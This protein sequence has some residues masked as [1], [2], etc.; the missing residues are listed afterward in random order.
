[1]V[2]FFRDGKTLFAVSTQTQLDN[3]T[4]E[5]LEWLF[6]GAKHVDS[7]KVEGI[8]VGP[9][10]E[11][12]TPWSTNAVEIT[13]NMGL[14]GIER[15]E[16]FTE[17]DSEHSSFD[18]MLQRLYKNGV[19]Q[20]VFVV[21][22]QPEPIVYI[23][24]IAEYNKQEGL[25]LNDNEIEYLQSVASRIGR[26]LTDSEVF[27]F[28]QV[29]SEHCR[30][31]IF[32]GE[33]RIDGE[34]KHE[35]LFGMIKKTTKTNPGRVVSAYKDNCAFLQ[36]PQ[37]EQFAP[38]HHNTSDYFEIKDFESVLTL[39]AETHNVPTT[40]EPFNGAATGTGGEIRDRI[41][42]GKGAF[43]VAGTAVYMTAYPRLEDGRSY[44]QHTQQRE[45]LYQTPAD[46]LIKASNG[47]SDFGNKFGQPLICGS[48]ET[49]EHFEN[50]DRYGFDKVIM[51]AGGI[52]YGKKQDSLKDEPEAGDKVV[53]L[54]GDNYR[55]GMGGGAVSSVAT[56]EYANAIEL[57]A[58][59][60]SNPE[61]QK[62]VYNAIRAI[63]EEDI[64]PSS[65]STTTEQEVT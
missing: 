25:A 16:Q 20:Q 11:M 1:M 52:G 58:I 3:K 15:I 36:G 53:L 49:F 42:G 41:A 59:Q 12:I 2:F 29:N 38:A 4:I 51:M 55:I 39:K 48:L 26:G 60:R 34:S 33:F 45:W 10:R 18:T 57:N 22:K 43:P 27:G 35:T 47:A 50:D 21:N 63:S 13:Q 32:N 14:E 17:V 28:S 6:S 40:V 30:H 65:L 44:E 9:R 23:D 5:A 31:K 37:A 7:D 61:M 8:F 56:G 19:D 24:D 64:N 46:I 62:R 54:G